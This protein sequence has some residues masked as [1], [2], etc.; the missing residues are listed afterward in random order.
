MVQHT[1]EGGDGA[2]EWLGLARLLG[3]WSLCPQPEASDL[4]GSPRLEEQA[5]AESRSGST[6]EAVTL[7]GAGVNMGFDTEAL[8]LRRRKGS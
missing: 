2:L 7:C 4:D 6:R 1:R 8:S 3:V 5:G